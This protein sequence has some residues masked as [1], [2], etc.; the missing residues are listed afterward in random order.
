MQVLTETFMFRPM[1]SDRYG[2]WKPS[3]I[4]TAM[5]EMAGTHSALLHLSRETLMEQHHAVWVLIRNELEIFHHPQV[6]D[7]VEASTWPGTVRRGLYPRY[8]TFKAQ[9]GTLLARAIGGWT[10]ADI[11]TRRM[12][13]LPAV[14]AMMPDTTDIKR[15]INY[16]RPVQLVSDGMTRETL[17]QVEF[18]DIDQNQHVNN[19]RCADWVCDLLGGRGDGE[20]LLK[21]RHVAALAANYRQE[22]TPGAPVTLRLTVQGDRFAMTCDRDDDRLLEVGGLLKSVS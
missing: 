9:D 13:D 19:T 14:A 6:G 5:Q 15:Y 1:Q 10:L 22:I 16:P 4:M 2:A 11:T 18:S 3:A 21:D 8:H 20:N 17:R 7:M 12:V